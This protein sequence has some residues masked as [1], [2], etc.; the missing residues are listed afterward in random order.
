MKSRRSEMQ[1]HYRS[2]DVEDC[3]ENDNGQ[4]NA[5]Q[6]QNAAFDHSELLFDFSLKRER[7]RGGSVAR[8][9]FVR[10]S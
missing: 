6:P 4:W 2:D 5:Q 1:R 9:F 3:Q 8:C 7:F 10:P